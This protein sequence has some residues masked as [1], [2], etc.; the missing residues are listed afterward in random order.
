MGKVDMVVVLALSCHPV[1]PV[2]VNNS[3]ARFRVQDHGCL[4]CVTFLEWRTTKL[5]R[6]FSA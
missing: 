6:C 4:A 2:S 1:I 5:S 3:C